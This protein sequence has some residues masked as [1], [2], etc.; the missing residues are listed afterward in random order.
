[1]AIATQIA[2]IEASLAEHADAERAAAEKRYLKSDLEFMGVGAGPTK[3]LVSAWLKARPGLTGAELVAVAQALWARRIHED[4]GFAQL[5]LSRRVKLLSP[6]DIA[7]VET[8]LRTSWTWAYVDHLATSVAGPVL[9]RH[10]RRASILNR[11]SVD[12]DFWIRRSSLLALLK[13]L[14]A[15]DASE[16]PRLCRYADAM[17]TDKQFFISKAIGWVLR[18]V[19]KKRPELV[20]EFV[21]AR[22]DRIRGVSIREAV[23]YLPAADRERLMAAYRDRTAAGR[24]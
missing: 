8:L 7:V 1:M 12:D 23:K 4:R 16:W 22:T 19:S 24:R 11:W 20:T 15:G 17:L 2:E 18:E 6:D 5:L 14:R 3:K 13:P 21:E 9:E 10:P